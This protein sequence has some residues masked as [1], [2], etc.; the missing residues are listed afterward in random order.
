MFGITAGL[1][2]PAVPAMAPVLAAIGA[3]GVE[4]LAVAA[5]RTLLLADYYAF[6]TRLP[7]TVELVTVVGYALAMLFAFGSARWRGVVASV[8]LFGI[9]WGEQFWLGLP[10]RLIFCERSGIP[11]D[12]LALAWPD[13]WPK[14]LGIA[15]GVVAAR[16][17]RQ[18]APGVMA[19]ALSVGLFA[20]S[21]PIGRIAFVPFLGQSPV[22][23][24]A[25]GAI[26]T[27]IAVQ[28][29]GALAGGLVAG[30]FG[31]R[32]I[33]DGLV[34][35]LY[36]IG[37]WW[38]QLLTFRDSPRPLI[39]AIDWQLLTPVGYALVAVLG[40]ALGA[41]VARYRATSVPTIP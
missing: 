36:F 4:S 11:C 13:L 22:G 21:F 20:L 2:R 19:L 18:G 41:V 12:L 9:I 27:I 16:V 33:L 23:E 40:L 37:P 5:I 34:L 10:G 35:A 30:F 1:R 15:I 39:L 25:G 8:G 7:R 32:R 17:V 14:L 31:K 29:V 38:P 28:L 3:L 26:N 6:G 24:A